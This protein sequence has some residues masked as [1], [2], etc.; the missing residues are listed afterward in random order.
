VRGS[1][2]INHPHCRLSFYFPSAW[3]DTCWRNFNKWVWNMGLSCPCVVGSKRQ[4]AWLTAAAKMR[5]TEYGSSTEVVGTQKCRQM[6]SI[7]PTIKIAAQY[8]RGYFGLQ[9]WGEKKKKKLAFQLTLACQL[10]PLCT[11]ASVVSVD[12]GWHRLTSVDI[13]WHLHFL[14]NHFLRNCADT[15]T[16]IV[17]E[18][19]IHR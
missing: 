9:R 15:E 8:C 12:I 16:M 10:A 6:P 3:R 18:L 19:T 4:T 14:R 7:Q 5:P 11:L 17:V 1:R 13:G 2:T